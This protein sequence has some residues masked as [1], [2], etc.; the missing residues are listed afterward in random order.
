MRSDLKSRCGIV[1]FVKVTGTVGAVIFARCGFV[2]VFVSGV[3]RD[4]GVCR[5]YVCFYYRTAVGD[6]RGREES[7]PQEIGRPAM[8]RV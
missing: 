1:G 7:K 3:V 6:L 2:A 4:H 8:T 5:R